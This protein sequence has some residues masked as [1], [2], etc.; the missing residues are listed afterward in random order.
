MDKRGARSN[1][2]RRRVPTV[3]VE[4]RAKQGRV[5]FDTEADS[6]AELRKLVSSHAHKRARNN[7]PTTDQRV[8][9]QSGLWHSSSGGLTPATSPPA[10]PPAPKGVSVRTRAG[11]ERGSHRRR[12]AHSSFLDSVQ[13]DGSRLASSWWAYDGLVVPDDDVVVPSG[14]V[15]PHRL[16]LV[17]HHKVQD[18]TLRA[19]VDGT[20][21][22]TNKRHILVAHNPPCIRREASPSERSGEWHNVTR[23]CLEPIGPVIPGQGMYQPRDPREKWSTIHIVICFR[24]GVKSCVRTGT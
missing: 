7:I 2:P 6:W 16:L 3:L 14:V 18:V 20:A 19:S 4:E 13:T 15:V 10:R 21:K 5:W 8:R 23:F 9:T 17:G 1:V 12:C 11:Q 22:Y 24:N